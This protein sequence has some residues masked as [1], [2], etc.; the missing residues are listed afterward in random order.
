MGGNDVV[1]MKVGGRGWGVHVRHWAN[2]QRPSAL[3]GFAASRENHRSVKRR[4]RRAVIPT[5]RNS[6]F[7]NWLAC[8]GPSRCGDEG[9][10]A[11]GAED[12]EVGNGGMA[13][14]VRWAVAMAGGSD[15]LAHQPIS[16]ICASPWA[17][18]GNGDGSCVNLWTTT[19][20]CGHERT[21]DLSTD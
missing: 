16:S 18:N 7:Q 11:E 5:L 20:L 1:K 2:R 8:A 3:G 14:K 15:H 17:A 13:Q 4:A 6:V 21:G 9:F 12:A 10:T 19:F